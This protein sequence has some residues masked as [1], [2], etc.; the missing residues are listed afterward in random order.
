[1]VQ[2][3]CVQTEDCLTQAPRKRGVFLCLDFVWRSKGGTP[4]FIPGKNLGVPVSPPER[5]PERGYPFFL[6]HLE[7]LFLVSGR[8]RRA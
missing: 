3:H 1:M 7:D 2:A 5:E 8:T 6:F 4:F